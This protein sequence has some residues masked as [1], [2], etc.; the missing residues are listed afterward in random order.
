MKFLLATAALALG[1]GPYGIAQAQ[2]W[3]KQPVKIVANFAPGGAADQLAR[4]ISAPLHEA[5]GQPVIVENKG[6]AG[7]NLGG[8]FV[9]KSAHDGYTLLML[10][11]IHI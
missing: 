11:L 3:P 2:D 8:E 7:G 9:A 10:S 6:G 5:L 1:L 4:V